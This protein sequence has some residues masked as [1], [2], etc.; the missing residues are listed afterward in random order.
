MIK[1][2]HFLILSIGLGVSLLPLLSVI[3]ST[4]I[5]GAFECT[6]H[7]GFANPC[8]VFGIDVGNVLASMFVAGW[9]MLATFP[10]TLVCLLLLVVLTIIKLVQRRRG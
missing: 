9:L 6:L 7:E 10:V 8:I 4:A 5:A 1:R 3:A 2:W